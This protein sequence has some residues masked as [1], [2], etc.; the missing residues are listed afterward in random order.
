[1][2][3]DVQTFEGLDR[4]CYIVEERLLRRN[5][6]LISRVAREA[7]VEIIDMRAG[8]AKVR[9][10]IT[11]A[12]LNAGGVCQ[13][14]ALFTMADLAFAIAVNMHGVLT[15]STSANITY[16]RSVSSG[17]V[18]AEAQ[19]IVDHKRMPFVEVRI[20]DDEGTL[21]AIFTSSGYRKNDCPIDAE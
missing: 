16:L 4:P 7:G 6:E 19:E 14:G 11:P 20:T 10:N 13:G 8:Y 5:L 18:Y 15:F 17:Y 12:H 9:M 3:I 1:M 21:V 2:K